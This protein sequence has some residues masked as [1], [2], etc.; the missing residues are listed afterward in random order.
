MTVATSP[1]P[2]AVGDS[3]QYQFTLT[4]PGNGSA[5]TTLTVTLPSQTTYG[6]S[7]VQRGPGCSASGTTVTCPL[8]F[9]PAGLTTTVLVCATVT[10]NGTLTM[11][12]S[13]S[14][15]P[16]DTNPA[17]SAVSLSLTVGGAVTPAPVP[18][19][20]TTKTTK[21][22]PIATLLVSGLKALS[23][24][25]KHPTVVFQLRASKTTSLTIVLLD[26]KGRKLASWT[27]KAGKGSNLLRLTLPSKARRAGHDRLKITAAGSRTPKLLALVLES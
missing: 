17:D 25:V 11:T 22:S 13:T 24:H 19:Q 8:D 6:G 15:Q 26:G 14:S 18:L 5:S 20:P 21:P 9:F 4:N 23:L 1:T 10:G 3:F 16:A 27:R 7:N 2:H 12:A